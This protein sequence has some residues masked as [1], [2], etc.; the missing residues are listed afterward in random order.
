M[1]KKVE[2]STQGRVDKDKYEVF[3]KVF[4][5]NKE[6]LIDL[7]MN[8]KF[9]IEELEVAE[10]VGAD[11]L[12]LK[13]EIHLLNEQQRCLEEAMYQIARAMKIEMGA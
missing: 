9:T 7:I 13:S 1:T 4:N 8:R 2:S 3:E 12:H 10:Q 6:L 11:K 5:L